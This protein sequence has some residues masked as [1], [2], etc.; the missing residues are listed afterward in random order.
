ML[1]RVPG[2]HVDR[3]A[4]R[5]RRDGVHANPEWR[6]FLGY[7]FH[8]QHHPGFR[9][10]V[11]HV[12]RPRITS[13]TELMQMIFPA[14]HEI[15]GRTPRRLNS[16]MASRAHRNWPVRLTPITLF[17]CVRVIWSTGASDCKPALLIKMSTVPNSSRT[18][19]NI[20]A[21]SSSLETSA[22]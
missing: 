9:G 1:G 14:Q 11:I 7:A 3:C 6:D 2:L 4:D 17:H 16:R 12:T 15:S 19:S 22:R 10:R 13:W 5:T 8:H 18:A 21:T 20:L